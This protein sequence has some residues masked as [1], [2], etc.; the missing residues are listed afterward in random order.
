LRHLRAPRLQELQINTMGLTARCAPRLAEWISSRRLG[1]NCGSCS[2][3]TLKCNG[4]NL[5]LNGVWE[6][7]HAIQTGNWS[8]LKVE[9]YANQIAEISN[10]NPHFQPATQSP[11]S[12]IEVSW[13]DAERALRGVLIR[14]AHWKSQIEK[15]ALSLLTYSRSLIFRP[16]TSVLSADQQTPSRLI[17]GSSLFHSLPIE[18]RLQIFA[19]LA[20]SLSG[21]QRARVYEYAADSSTLPPLLPPLRR[22][23][24]HSCVPDPSQPLG[25]SVGFALHNSGGCAEG[26]CMGTGNSLVCRREAER[27]KFL[28]AVRCCAYEPE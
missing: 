12:Q 28:A 2:L 22:G 20:P 16:R 1:H 25:A 11:S 14:N 19:V 23:V 4:N 27:A 9:L 24:R 17:S 26:K 13:R 21:A 15:E 18:L 5:A 7:I 10:H 6:I 8:L 3:H